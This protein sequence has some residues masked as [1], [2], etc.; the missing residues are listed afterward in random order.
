MEERTFLREIKL[1]RL[2]W[3]S[4]QEQGDEK[5]SSVVDNYIKKDYNLV[6]KMSSKLHEYRRGKEEVESEF[7]SFLLR[8][9]EVVDSFERIFSLVEEN[10]GNISMSKE[11]GSVLENFQRI[12][13]SL[14]KE[15]SRIGLCAYEVKVGERIDDQDRYKVVGTMEHNELP[16]RVVCEVLK[17]GYTWKDKILRKAHVFTVKNQ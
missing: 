6:F 16:D 10:K 17:K 4:F 7:A 8:L 5:P 11:E 13:E 1:L 12:Y 9:L 3:W 15:L 14:M 2:K